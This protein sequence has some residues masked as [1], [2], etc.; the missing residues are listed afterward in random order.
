MR[1]ISIKFASCG[2]KPVSAMLLVLPTGSIC[3]VF[4]SVIIVRM[5]FDI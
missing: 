2:P 5:L 4:A 1:S 3:W